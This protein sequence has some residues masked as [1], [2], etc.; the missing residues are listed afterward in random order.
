[1][2]FMHKVH[3]SVI[4]PMYN[5]ERYITRCLESLNH[6]SFSDFE[7]ILID[8]WSTDRT[9]ERASAYKVKILK[10]NHGWPGK[11]RNR[12]AK[13]ATG[14]ILIFVDADMYF[15]KDYIKNLLNPILHGHEAGTAH[16]V[17]KVGNPENIRAKTRCIDRIPNPPKR[18]WVYR[19]I[20]RD[21]FLDAGWFDPSKWYFDD[22]LSKINHWKGALTVMDAVCYHNNPETLS[23]AF[24][25][26]VRVG[27]SLAQSWEIRTYLK[28]YW[29]VFFVSLIALVSI[30]VYT[31]TFWFF[32]TWALCLFVFFLEIIALKR[33]AKEHEFR[34]LLT[35]PIL[36][37]IRFAGYVFGLIKFLYFVRK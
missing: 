31:D 20:K 2:S 27:K 5:E 29:V 23:E 33:V 37:T 11:A 21:L 9:V 22:N 8:D 26:S 34:Y 17:E 4:I 35:V 32:M 24:K 7:I 18:S 19:A 1:M 6:Q 30:A 25:H 36:R 16:G 14:D 3:A 28:K 12:W 13:E 10:Q 15:D